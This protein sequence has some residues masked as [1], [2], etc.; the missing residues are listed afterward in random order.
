MRLLCPHRSTP[1]PS[2]YWLLT[3]VVAGLLA[4]GCQEVDSPAELDHAQVL[5]VQANPAQ[6]PAGGS[7]ELD[8]LVAGPD[9]DIEILPGGLQWTVSAP[10]FV[11]GPGEV[12]FAAR[13]D[14]PDGSDGSAG[15]AWQ[16]RA[17]ESLAGEP[18]MVT[19]SVDIELP[20]GQEIP[21]LA[22]EKIIMLGVDSVPS[23]RVIGLAMN[24]APIDERMALLPG[25]RAELSLEVESA[26]S[27]GLTTWHA[28]CGT[29]E[30]YRE[31]VALYEAPA[32]PCTGVLYAIHR[33]ELGGVVWHSV[34]VVVARQ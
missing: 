14:D 9:G 19:L 31:S 7:A 20:E 1:C 16:Y 30:Q 26:T 24:G 2:R 33:D 32:E 5:A 28:T 15:Q 4:P 12:V 34:P 10:G 29:L 18:V 3:G 17:P 13:P 22:A 21:T 8:V 25:D 11:S 23:P 6:I 27:G